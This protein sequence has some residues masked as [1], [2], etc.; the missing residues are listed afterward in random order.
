MSGGLDCSGGSGAAF[1]T[2]VLVYTGVHKARLVL[3]LMNIHPA[4][5][6]ETTVC[7]VGGSV[8]DVTG[9]A[10]PTF[11]LP[12][13]VY[14]PVS[15]VREGFTNSTF[16]VSTLNKDLVLFNMLKMSEQPTTISV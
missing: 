15:S 9:T 7:S 1:G 3:T 16:W 11:F 4:R 6:T 5:H 2:A 14:F 8:R 10:A 12:T 13:S